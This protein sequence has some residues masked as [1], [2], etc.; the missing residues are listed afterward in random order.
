MTGRDGDG[1][2]LPHSPGTVA[3]ARA[4]IG[5]YL[6]TARPGK[7]AYYEADGRPI[8]VKGQ[9]QSRLLAR[10]SAGG[11]GVVSAKVQPWASNVADSIARL[12]RKGVSIA[13]RPGKP[14]RYVLCS[15]VSQWEAQP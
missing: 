7:W 12:K 4:M 10:Q 14:A 3:D 2:A 13:I 5:V 9:T 8:K 6:P 1:G 11:G 15:Q